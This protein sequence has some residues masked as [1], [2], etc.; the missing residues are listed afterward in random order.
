MT[1]QVSSEGGTERKKDPDLKVKAKR[2]HGSRMD[3]KL[4][5]DRRQRNA[6]ST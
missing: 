2:I 1:L 5:F 3:A 6:T 4:S